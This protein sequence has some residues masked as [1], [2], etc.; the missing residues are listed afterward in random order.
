MECTYKT[1]KFYSMYNFKSLYFNKFKRMPYILLNISFNK[2]SICKF[3]QYKIVEVKGPGD[4]LSTKQKLWL[5][6]LSRLGLNTEVCY[7]EVI[8]FLCYKSSIILF[9]YIF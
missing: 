1:G 4:S 7:C 2:L 5:D 8:T 3:F 9:Y 6:Y